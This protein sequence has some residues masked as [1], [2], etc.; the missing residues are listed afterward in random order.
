MIRWTAVAVLVAAAMAGAWSRPLSAQCEAETDVIVIEASVNNPTPYVGEQ[1]I[2]SVQIFNT[3]QSSPNLEIPPFEGFWSAGTLAIAS[4]E[5]PGD[6]GVTVG[7]TENERI[8]FPL[9]PDQ[10][11]IPPVQ[12]DFSRNPVYE[13]STRVE[14]STVQVEVQPL[15]DGAPDGF[16]GAVG[17]AFF[18][19]AAVGRTTVKVGDPV[20]LRLAIEG[21]GNIEQLNPPELP[22]PEEWRTY[23]QPSRVETASQSRLLVGKKTFEWLF[24]PQEVGDLVVPSIAFHYFDTNV[25]IY[26]TVTTDPIVMSILPADEVPAAELPEIAPEVEAGL[27]ALKS[28]GDDGAPLRMGWL[29][30][31]WLLAPLAFVGTL[32]WRWEQVRSSDEQALLRQRH[33]LRN[34]KTN[35]AQVTRVQGDV[36]YQ[37]L[38]DAVLTYFGDKW[39]QE[40]LSLQQDDLRGGMATRGVEAETIEQVLGCLR[41]AE[42]GR[43]A[44][45]GGS[46]PRALI[47]QTMLALIAAESALERR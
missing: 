2:Y 9:R 13:A 6:C 7:V 1:V 11:V 14:S 28:V 47:K 42:E 23:P 10:L 22:F 8:L 25:D 26:R 40:P 18:T 45:G 32:W 31:L 4:Y 35:L 21:A 46:P 36:A 29:W 37:R 38:I 41:T 12:L 39:N 17:T 19:E 5:R 16:A 15:P 3:T 20:L 33:A 43:Y 24:V 44:P 30:G 27:L 34:A